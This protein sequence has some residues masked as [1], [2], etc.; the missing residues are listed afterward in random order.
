MYT[1]RRRPG[2]KLEPTLVPYTTRCR[3]ESM[4]EDGRQYES[5]WG[6]S[7][8]KTEERFELYVYPELGYTQTPRITHIV[9]YDEI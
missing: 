6:Y 4:G 1:I 2:Y 8:G 3:S 5:I 9:E 7:G